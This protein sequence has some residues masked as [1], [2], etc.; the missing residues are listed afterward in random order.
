M[1]GRRIA[2]LNQELAS[3][4]LDDNKIVVY[5]WLNF[6]SCIFIIAA[7]L[8]GIIFGITKAPAAWTTTSDAIVSDLTKGWSDLDTDYRLLWI[9]NRKNKPHPNRKRAPWTLDVHEIA[10][11]PLQAFEGSGSTLPS[12]TTSQQT[13]KLTPAPAAST[14]LQPNP[15]S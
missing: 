13:A 3:R 9:S 1:D 11:P 2:I 12:Y 6:V 15:D 4:P 5:F 8:S 10:M 14:A 7:L